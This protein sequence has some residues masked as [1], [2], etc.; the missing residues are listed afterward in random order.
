MALLSNEPYSA[1]ISFTGR[2]WVSLSLLERV[3]HF[4]AVGSCCISD[5][6]RLCRLLKFLPVLPSVKSGKSPLFSDGNSQVAGK[7]SVASFRSRL[8]NNAAFYRYDNKI[9]LG[10][11]AANRGRFV[12][13]ALSQRTLQRKGQTTERLKRVIKGKKQAQHSEQHAGET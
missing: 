8:D 12:F 10:N 4:S 2:G 1:R 13:P 6:Y 11:H 7:H 9:Y 3:C 5:F